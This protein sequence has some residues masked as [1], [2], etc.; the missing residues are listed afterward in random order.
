A[1]PELHIQNVSSCTGNHAQQAAGLAR[2]IKMYQDDSI[3]FCSF[4]ESAMSEGYVYEAL[5]GVSRERLPVMFIIQDN[6]YAIS[7]PKREQT[8]HARTADNLKGLPTLEILYC[9]GTDPV[10]SW[11]AVQKGL[12]AIRDR[13]VGVIVYADCVRIGS[14]SNSD[15]HFLY[16]DERE[17]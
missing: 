10:D 15:N 3:V 1:K 13:K 5:N 2:A 11:R 8:A 6:G 16:R 4:G 9:D 14:H 12:A 7:V 17:L